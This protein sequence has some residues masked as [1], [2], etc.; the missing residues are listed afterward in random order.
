MEHNTYIE[1]DEIDIGELL[2]KLKQNIFRILFIT[3]LAVFSATVYLYFIQSS[4]SSNVTISLDSQEN[5]NFG[6]IL[7]N[8]L[9]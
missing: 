2:R 5:S 8:Q 7:P 6:K 9:F 1:E 4:Y 3:F